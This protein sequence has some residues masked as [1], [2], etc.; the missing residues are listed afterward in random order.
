MI[1]QD[2]GAMLDETYLKHAQIYIEYYFTFY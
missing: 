2:M 1:I